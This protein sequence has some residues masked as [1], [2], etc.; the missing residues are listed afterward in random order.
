M[1]HKGY[2]DPV[3]N[4]GQRFHSNVLVSELTE[5]VTRAIEASDVSSAPPV[6]KTADGVTYKNSKPT[7]SEP[8]WAQALEMPNTSA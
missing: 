8:N 1:P 6:A 7:P 2:A 4:D 3:M 5:H